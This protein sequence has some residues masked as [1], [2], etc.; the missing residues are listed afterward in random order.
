[1][2]LVLVS[3]GVASYAAYF[4]IMGVTWGTPGIIGVIIVLYIIGAYLSRKNE[5]IT[6]N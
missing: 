2:L 3:F 6:N 4:K 5:T 1:M